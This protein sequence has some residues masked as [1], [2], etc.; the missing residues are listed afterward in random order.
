MPGNLYTMSLLSS[1]NLSKAGPFFAALEQQLYQPIIPGKSIN[2][3][4]VPVDEAR[5][6]ARQHR[7]DEFDDVGEASV[8][9]HY[10]DVPFEV[11][12]TNHPVDETEKVKKEEEPTLDSARQQK[13]VAEARE[14]LRNFIEARWEDQLLAGYI[15]I[16][17]D[18]TMFEI[19]ELGRLDKANGLQE[20]RKL[21][22]APVIHDAIG[23][24]LWS[25]LAGE[26]ATGREETLGDNIEATKHTSTNTGED[27]VVNCDEPNERRRSCCPTG[28]VNEET[29]YGWRCHCRTVCAKNHFTVYGHYGTRATN[30]R[31]ALGTAASSHMHHL[32]EQSSAETQ[33]R[34]QRDIRR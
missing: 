4:T 19:R 11:D 5:S 33:A 23:Y 32:R 34:R 24:A 22:S 16:Q 9:K 3:P 13:S 20:C 7:T 15:K 2:G 21:V 31:F 12:V 14:F 17:C 28:E 1:S 27:T 6:T 26:I 10:F 30:E 25:E 8:A 29:G 18:L